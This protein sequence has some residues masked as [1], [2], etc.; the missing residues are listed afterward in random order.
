MNCP[1]CRALVIAEDVNLQHLLAK[2]R[3]CNEV[4][5]FAAAEVEAITDRV[6]DDGPRAAP[7]LDNE[8]MPDIAL[9]TLRV[10]QPPTIEIDPGAGTRRIVKRWFDYSYL[11]MIFFCVFWDGFLFCWY[12]LAFTQGGPWIMVLFPLLHVTVGVC[13]TYSTLA[14][15][16]NRTVISIEDGFLVTTHGPLPWWGGAR[17][18]TSGIVQLYCTLASIQRWRSGNAYYLAAMPVQ[19]N[20]LMQNGEQRVVLLSATKE[21][22]LFLEQTLEDWLEIEPKRVPGQVD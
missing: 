2:C 14:G 21:E 6:R 20:A 4:F 18:P 3:Q 13:I 7:D 8:P 9:K 17:I 10:P 1:R 5:R 15:L 11:G 22:G 19:L 16:F 12:T